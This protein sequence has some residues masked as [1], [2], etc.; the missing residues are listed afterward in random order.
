MLAVTLWPGNAGAD[1]AADLLD[2]LTQAVAQ[3]LPEHRRRLL[4]RGDSAGAT[5]AVLDWLIGRHTVRRT[6]ECSLGWSIGET[7]RATI[8]GRPPRR[9]HPAIVTNTTSGALQWLEARHRAHARVE[10][11][12][13]CAKDTGLRRPPSRE[14]AIDRAWC[15]AAAIAADLIAWLQLIGLDGDLAKAEPK[16]LRYPDPAH[17]RPPRARPTPPLA[18]H[19]LQLTRA[20]QIPHRAFHRI[21]AIPAPGLTSPAAAPTTRRTPGDHARRRD[22]RPCHH[23]RSPPTS[24]ISAQVRRAERA[25]VRRESS[26]L[27]VC[28]ELFSS[29][30][31]VDCRLSLAFQEEGVKDEHDSLC[32][33]SFNVALSPELRA[34]EHHP[35]RLLR[36]TG[37]TAEASHPPA[38]V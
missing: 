20:E 16:R 19:P 1:T 6:L 37:P 26:R 17:R 24:T 32:L 30:R 23:A 35:C 9:G 31:R 12:I 27:V 18:T 25:D 29:A 11:R 4:I 22:R 8:V 38:R 14:L 10:D 7:E 34:P 2:V 15:T 13:R 33:G 3:V 36:E 21:T 5:H 28:I